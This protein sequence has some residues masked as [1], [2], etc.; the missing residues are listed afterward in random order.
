MMDKTVEKIYDNWGNAASL[1][2]PDLV[3]E[4]ER[5]FKIGYQYTITVPNDPSLPAKVA[6]MYNR[7]GQT[8]NPMPN[9]SFSDGEMR[10]PV[11]DF[12]D[13]ILRRVPADELAEGLWTDEKV[14]ERFIECM[15][16]RCSGPSVTDADRRKVLAGLQQEVYAVAVDEAVRRLE[17]FESGLRAAQTR[18][19]CDHLQIGH[20]NSLYELYKNSLFELREHGV[21]S[22]EQYDKR[23]ENLTTPERLKEFMESR[24]DP[25]MK[26]RI[27]EQWMESRDY[28][29]K[30][31]EL[32]FPEPEGVVETD[33]YVDVFLGETEIVDEGG[34][35]AEVER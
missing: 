12:A 7:W 14:R 23:K 32:F 18:W 25:I 10:I 5:V 19:D 34:K 24:A 22:Q 21:L 16:S 33:E 2:E 31:L 8:E 3:T 17:N 35:A 15:I 4:T 28:W 6:H 20:Y 13:L 30:R 26:E 11:E 9:M 29:R 27:G 1:K